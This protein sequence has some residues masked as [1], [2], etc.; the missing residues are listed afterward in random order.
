MLNPLAPPRPH[1]PRRLPAR[2][3][4]LQGQAERTLGLR[5]MRG[6][7]MTDRA[8]TFA[9]TLAALLV[10]HNVG[11]HLVSAA[12]AVSTFDRVQVAV[13]TSRAAT[14]RFAAVVSRLPLPI[15]VSEITRQSVAA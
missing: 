14:R 4:L 12:N 3:R 8:A 13:R 2:G 5:P 6:M 10:G 11:D 9:A 1:V 7:T 15:F